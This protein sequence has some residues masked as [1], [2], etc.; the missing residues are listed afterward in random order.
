MRCY[1]GELFCQKLLIV[2]C[3]GMKKIF[4]FVLLVPIIALSFFSCKKEKVSAGSTRSNHPP[5]AIT[6]SDTFIILPNNWIR[7]DGS[8][9]TDPDDKILSYQWTK[10]AGP[11]SFTILNAKIAQTQV[12]NLVEGVYQISFLRIRYINHSDFHFF[13]S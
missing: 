8:N 2:N 3:S 9:S 12:S 4:L 10:I 1:Y 7:L 6:N 11:Y 5:I 13:V